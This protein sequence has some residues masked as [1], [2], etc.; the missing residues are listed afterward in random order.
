MS[1]AP[2]PNPSPPGA[3]TRER[4]IR[5]MRDALA[6]Q[7]YHGI[8]LADLL[9]RAEAP[10]GVLYH[11]FPGGKQELALAAL[12]EV[13][14]EVIASL[15]LVFER[16][17]LAGGGTAADALTTW[18]ASASKRLEKSAFDRG[19]ALAAVALDT[20]NEDEVLRAALRSAFATLRTRLTEHLTGAGHPRAQATGLATLIVS[21]YEGALIQARVAGQAQAM[22]DTAATLAELIRAG[23]AR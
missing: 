22:R 20:T 10:K 5:A 9:A 13:V 17:V 1:P 23:S 4:L 18:M 16:V 15:D 21:A 8:G 6:V 19:C 12:D 3:S 14:R 2:T 11:H 7:G